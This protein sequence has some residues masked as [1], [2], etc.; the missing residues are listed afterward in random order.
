MNGHSNGYD[1]K[2]PPG[3]SP[4]LVLVEPTEDE[5]VIQ[6]TKNAPAWRG[7][8]SV[9]AY[10]RRERFLSSQDN[11]KDGGQ[12]WWVL[13]DEAA[14]ERILLAG[15]ESFR[16]KAIVAKDGQINDVITH[17]VGSVFSPPEHRGKGYAGRMMQEVGKKLRTWQTSEKTDCLFS[18][19][20]SDIGKMRK[21]FYANHGWEPFRSAHISVPAAAEQ[22][23]GA[24]LPPVKD[25][26][27][28]D[29]PDLCAHD[30]S[31]LRQSLK[32]GPSD[33]KT[34]VAILPDIHTIRWHHAREEFIGKEFYGNHPVVKGA[35]IGEEK[36]KRVWCYWTRMWYNADKNQSKG[37][38]LHI[39]RLVIEDGVAPDTV[40]TSIA[41]LLARAQREAAGW[42]MAEVEAWSPTPEV[43]AAA[44]LLEPTAEVI[45][46]DTESIASLMWYG[47]QPA[48][49]SSIADAI[50]WVGNE[51]YGWC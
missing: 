30:E 34:R 21:K 31:M 32:D 17:G 43:V 24:E 28:A 49:G 25:L 5:K 7:A 46:R 9:E 16:K 35:M 36:G 48:D 19:L 50:E 22:S 37:N 29:L 41:A 26:G 44:Q 33:G 42:H 1:H 13:V 45:D 3:D 10:I 51:K 18:I 8:L 39:L 11:T 15:C 38:T 12:T 2:L 47:E 4:T 14:S 20:Y 40:V 23:P 6:W 27:A